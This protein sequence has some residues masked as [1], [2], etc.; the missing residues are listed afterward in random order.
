MLVVTNYPNVPLA[1][2]NVATDSL[3]NDSQQ[4]PPVI[5]PK[6]LTK[7]HE[8]RA[9]NSQNER[10][11]EQA[12]AQARLGQRIQGKANLSSKIKLRIQAKPAL[13]RRDIHI[14]QLAPQAQQTSNKINL[15]T[16]NKFTGQS[17][18]F[19]QAVSAHITNVYQAHA[20]PDNEPNNEPGLCA[21]I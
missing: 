17:A 15:T 11:A 21:Y 6:E 1:T 9:F 5:P 14:M 13:N 4:K 20:Q 3:R 12:D 19:Y 2:S 7:G 10:T 16:T 8:E 18:V